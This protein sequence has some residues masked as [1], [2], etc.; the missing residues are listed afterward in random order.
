MGTIGP[1]EPPTREQWRTSHSPATPGDH[2]RE[3]VTGQGLSYGPPAS[4]ARLGCPRGCP[5]DLGSG[6]GAKP[7]EG[8]DTKATYPDHHRLVAFEFGDEFVPTEYLRF[9]EG[10]EPAH[11]FDAAF[12][13]IRHLG[14]RQEGMRGWGAG[15]GPGWAAP[16]REAAN[17]PL[18]SARPP[19]AASRSL[20]AGHRDPALDSRQLRR[21]NES[22]LRAGPPC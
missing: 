13:W 10:P 9:V 18:P 15:G 17:Q 3:G 19:P 11:H 21:G 1:P 6:C 7:E 16:P 20:S 8:R 2:R 22:R 4:P 5:E 12:G 14:P